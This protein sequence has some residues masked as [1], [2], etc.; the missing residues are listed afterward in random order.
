VSLLALYVGCLVLG[1]ILIGASMIGAGHDAHGPAGNGPDPDAL[2]HGEPGHD[3]LGHDPDE[4]A[5]PTDSAVAGAHGEP[6]SSASTAVLATL[7]SLR[8]WTFALAAFGMTGALLTLVGVAAPVGLGFAAVTGFGVGT[9]VTVL[10]RMLSRETVS[11]A[12]ETASLR[13]RDAEV[14]LAVGPGK[15]GK[16]RLSCNGQT[17][18]LAAGTREPRTLERHE[19]VLIVD[20]A[21]G[22]ADVT[23]ID[24]ERLVATPLPPTP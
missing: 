7:L 15:I 11:S 10:L 6:S 3:P 22:T 23:P 19:R 1:G 20:V 16:I 4:H 18:E 14:V 13:G 8:F 12:L 2:T 17:L 24:P 5:F 9:G 21:D